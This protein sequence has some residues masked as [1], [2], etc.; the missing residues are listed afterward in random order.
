MNYN[1]GL[2][3]IIGQLAYSL[4]SS[5]EALLFSQKTEVLEGQQCIIGNY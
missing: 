4:S 3:A 2:H 5:T 1:L